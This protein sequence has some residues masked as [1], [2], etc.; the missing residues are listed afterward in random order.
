MTPQFEPVNHS[1]AC[2][3][4]VTDGVMLLLMDWEGETLDDFEPDCVTVGT[5]DGDTVSDRETDTDVLSKGDTL[6]V[7]V[8]DA[9]TEGDAETDADNDADGVNVG[10][11]EGDAA[12]FSILL[13]AATELD[14]KSCRHSRC[15]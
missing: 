9:E 11:N 14:E 15:A 10:V 1:D 6:E 5:F 3:D 8:I 7:A 4:G 12:T 2:T 13:H